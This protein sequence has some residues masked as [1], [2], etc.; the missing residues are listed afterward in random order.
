MATTTKAE[1]VK[2]IKDP[3]QEKVT[4][5]VPRESNGEANYLI[6]SVNGR[7]FKIQR[8]INVEVPLPIAEVIEHSFEAEEEAISYID[9]LSN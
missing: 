9:K 4:I 1:A 2:E 8:G 7:V 6:A 3:W 5:R